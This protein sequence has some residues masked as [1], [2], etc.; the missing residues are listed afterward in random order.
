M[1]RIEESLKKL[2][3]MRAQQGAAPSAAP[4]A[5]AAPKAPAPPISVIPVTAKKKVSFD[6]AAKHHISQESLVHGG[7]L[8][9]LDH[10]TTVA[11]EFRKIKRPLI[12]NAS[13]PASEAGAHMNIIMIASALPGAGKT[14]C[15]VNL[16]VSI[17]LERELNVVL[18][19]A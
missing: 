19:D 9:S 11:D 14:F 2:R 8:A 18:V 1:S 16:A 17:S 7:L 3:T 4:N 10:A 6:G 15:A 12:V 5:A 13:K